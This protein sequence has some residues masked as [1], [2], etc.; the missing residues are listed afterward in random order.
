MWLAQISV[1]IKLNYQAVLRGYV[2][3]TF[4]YFRGD[5]CIRQCRFVYYLNN[6][7]LVFLSK[8]RLRRDPGRLTEGCTPSG[9]AC[10]RRPGSKEP[11]VRKTINILYLA[12]NV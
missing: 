9:T 5:L 7:C 12:T 1:T 2:E 11:K 6:I 10:S 4:P 3:A 8:P